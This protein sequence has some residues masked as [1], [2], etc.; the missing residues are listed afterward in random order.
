MNLGYFDLCDGEKGR[1]LLFGIRAALSFC[2]ALHLLSNHMGRNMGN[3]AW[4]GNG[5][6]K[7]IKDT[8]F[9]LRS[10]GLANYDG[11]RPQLNLEKKWEDEK[12]NHEM[13]SFVFSHL[14]WIDT[15]YIGRAGMGM[16]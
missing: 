10:F 13:K 12:R 4:T 7:G 1:S 5:Q 6:G 11:P 16:E 3:G 9:G 2:F 8:K 15:R 14:R